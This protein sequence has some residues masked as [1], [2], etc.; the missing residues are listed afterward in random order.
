MKPFIKIFSGTTVHFKR[1]EPQLA[2]WGGGGL[3]RFFLDYTTDS[4]TTHGISGGK[5]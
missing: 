2:H 4:T 3:D 1:V 5:G